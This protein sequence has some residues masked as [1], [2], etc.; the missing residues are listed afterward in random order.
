MQP[1][2]ELIV[3][4]GE[5]IGTPLQAD[6][7]QSCRLEFPEDDVIAQIDLDVRGDR[8]L[9]G[10]QLST[11]PP[12]IHREQVLLTAMHVNGLP[13]S[14]RGHLAYSERND[15]LVLY[16]F[17]DLA[18]LDVEKLHNFLKLFVNHARLWREALKRGDVPKIA[19]G[20]SGSSVT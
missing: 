19:E 5:M 8:V 20:H 15:E 14:P 16:Q 2:E 9:V 12:G 3:A 10:S 13:R 6:S 1:Y 4:L 18:T 7:R 17:L 11:L